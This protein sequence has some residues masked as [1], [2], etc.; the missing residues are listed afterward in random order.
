MF[1]LVTAYLAAVA[2]AFRATLTAAWWEESAEAAWRQCQQYVGPFL[3]VVIGTGQFDGDAAATVAVALGGAVL[4]VFGR[5][6]LVLR[7]PAGAGAGVD[8]TFRVLSAF[9]GSVAGFAAVDGF[10][11]LTADWRAVMVASAATAGLAFLG[12]KVD[13]AATAVRA[14]TLTVEYGTPVTAVVTGVE[15]DGRVIG[16]DTATDR[17]DG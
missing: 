5:R 7:A 8:L 4:V 14:D 1:G 3:L 17:T 6:L 10:N 16:H 11:L 15:F 12:G 13:P 2:A 9:A